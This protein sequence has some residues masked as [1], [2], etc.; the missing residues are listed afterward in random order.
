M[1]PNPESSWEEWLD[2]EIETA[3]TALG[4]E[5][6]EFSACTVHK[7]GR[8]TGGM[9]YYEG[10]MTAFAEARR[11]SRGDQELEQALTV[12][13]R[14][15]AAE[16]EKRK[17]ATDPSPPWVAYATGGAEALDEVLD[18]FARLARAGTD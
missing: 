1:T 10:R 2:A 12:L 18:E 11:A 7:D 15:W 9:K 13:A 3:A 17:G 4:N 14:T 6:G 5:L 16:L 8:V